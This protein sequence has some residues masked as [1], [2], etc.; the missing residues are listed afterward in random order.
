MDN[1]L[2]IILKDT[3]SLSELKARVSSLKAKLLKDFFGTSEDLQPQASQINWLNSLPSEVLTNFNKD[4]VYSV[5]E[6]LE[7]KITTLTPLTI[8]LSFEPDESSL[9][10][11]GQYARMAFNNP[12]LLLEI[13]YNPALIAGAA[14]SWKGILR[15]YSLHSRIEERKLA[16]LE[17]YKKFLH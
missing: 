11:I 3:Y 5:F 17:N 7:K 9:N 14:L 2:N 12:T 8:F 4:N 13:K 10:S 16:I 1:L 6:D 15:D